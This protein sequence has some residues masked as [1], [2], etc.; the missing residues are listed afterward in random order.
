MSA[1]FEQHAQIFWLCYGMAVKIKLARM[2]YE[3]L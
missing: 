1:R 3:A 2:N